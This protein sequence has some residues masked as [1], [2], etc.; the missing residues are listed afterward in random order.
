MP[1]SPA[2]AADTPWDMEGDV[3]PGQSRNQA[4]VLWDESYYWAL[5]LWRALRLGRVPFRLVRARDI[6]AGLL[7]DCPP[8]VLLVPGG[9]ARF[10][11]G[12]LGHQGRQAIAAYLEGGGTYLGFCGGAGLALPEHGGLALCPLCRKPM[13]QRLPNFSGFVAATMHPHPLVPASIPSPAHVPV[14]WPSQFAVPL[15]AQV[16]VLASYAGPGPDFWVSDLAWEDF[17]RQDPEPWQQLYGINLDPGLLTGEPCVV[18]GTY[19]KGRYILSYAHLESPASPTANFW[20]GHMLSLLLEQP[21]TCAD[22]LIVP[23]WDLQNEPVHWDEPRLC[24]M[25]TYLDE[26]IALGMRNFLLFWRRPW[27]LGWRR[28]VPGFALTTL[29]AQL[30]VARSLEP[31]A[32]ALTYWAGC[33]VGVTQEMARFRKNMNAY[34]VAWR[35]SM[36]STPSS[37]AAPPLRRSAVCKSELLQAQRNVLVGEFPGYG[38][39]FGR[40]AGTLDEL[41]W[42]LCK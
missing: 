15:A 40:I 19:G 27:L 29:F 32:E 25:A 3:Q 33:A 23:D 38:G 35:P 39:L 34:L 41:L 8:A 4:Y 31:S 37:P 14:W 20:L 5:M 21:S 9:W 12:A 16:E 2:R 26:I 28:G 30:R 18:S 22:P 42:L 13:S 11:S 36:H 24:Q 6:A 1:L 10:K 17:G 7:G